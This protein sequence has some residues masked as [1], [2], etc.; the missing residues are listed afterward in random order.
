M[1]Y[2]L[3]PACSTACSG[4]GAAGRLGAAHTHSSGLGW[5]RR[6]HAIRAA[7]RRVRAC[8]LVHASLRA[9]SAPAVHALCCLG[10][11]GR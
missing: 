7:P 2:M 4:G 8:A 5:R 9:C 10:S 1:E 11:P 3:C 6:L